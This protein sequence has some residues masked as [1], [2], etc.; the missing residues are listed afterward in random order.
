MDYRALAAR[1]IERVPLRHRS[2]L[3][4]VVLPFL[5]AAVYYGL[6][7]SDRYV[8]EAKF[9]VR[10]SGGGS[11]SSINLH[12]LG[13]LANPAVREDTLLLRE[14]ILSLDMLNLLQERLKIREHYA[15]PA[16]DR[17]SRFWPWETQEKFLEYY[18]KR[19]GAEFDDVSG[20]LT[21][22]VQA[23][24]P[25][26]ARDIV[27]TILAASEEFVNAVGHEMAREQLEFVEQEVGL[28]QSRLKDR[29]QEVLAF[30]SR[31]K[32]V[33]PE[34]VTQSIGGIIAGLESEL[35]REE[36][37]LKDLESYLNPKAAEVK[38]ARFRINA[39]KEQI[40]KETA[41]LAGNDRQQDLSKLSAEFQELQLGVEFATD[42][43]KSSI[44]S[45]EQTR[46]EASRKLKHL[47]TVVSPAVPEW[48]LLPE[49]LYSLAT[50]LVFL[51]LAYGIGRLVYAT[52]LDHRE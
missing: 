1:A 4:V 22:R 11:T 15:S 32:L 45:F 24:T 46:V 42:L 18:L 44:A 6:I 50:I 39:L 23:F 8:S 35:A 48:P 20:I 36:A 14:H 21:V 9:M 40:V 17:L 13:V 38:S 37:S 3:L 49:R 2:F 28:S 25:Q 12:L 31:H 5:L 43:Y 41:R 19:V 33:S 29:K 27:Q 16:W 7:A 34:D 52:V 30:Q 47:V 51:L 26:M 10:E